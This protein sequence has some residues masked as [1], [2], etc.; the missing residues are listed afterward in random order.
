MTGYLSVPMY[1]G[2]EVVKVT[3]L[4]FLR[5]TLLW[6]KLIDKYQGTTTAAPNFAYNLLAKR[7][8][9]GYAWPVRPLF[10][11]V[12]TV[13]RR[14]ARCSPSRSNPRGISSPPRS[15][16]SSGRWPTRCSPRSTFGPAPW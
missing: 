8:Q 6:A 16:A 15:A 11:A 14:V 1:Y 7:A 2:V 5:D 9:A 10:A 4:N 13:G 12:G 3:P